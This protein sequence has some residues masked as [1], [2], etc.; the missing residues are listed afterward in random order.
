MAT[1]LGITKT[2]PC[3]ATSIALGALLSPTRAFLRVLQARLLGDFCIC[4]PALVGRLQE[5]MSESFAQYPS[6][7]AAS[8]YA[9]RL[10]RNDKVR[11][12][13][14]GALIERQQRAN[15]DPDEVVRYWWAVGKVVEADFKVVSEG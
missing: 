7:I 4:R 11:T 2:S 1:L 5:P 6:G 15:H 10:L 8:V 13:I 3:P 12:A 9:S 14:R